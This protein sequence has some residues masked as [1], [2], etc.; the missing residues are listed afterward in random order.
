M[1]SRKTWKKRV[2]WFFSMKL[3][4]K[5]VET[6]KTI[7]FIIFATQALNGGSESPVE[8]QSLSQLSR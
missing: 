5:D 4:A 1:E 8:F 7:K 6:A 3:K 2:Q